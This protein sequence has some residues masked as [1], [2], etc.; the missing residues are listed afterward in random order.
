MT[1]T[2]K[3]AQ[4]IIA[5]E[6]RLFSIGNWVAGPGRYDKTTVRC[7]LE[8]RV[9]MEGTLRRGLWFR[10]YLW[11]SYPDVATFQ[12]E[13]DM[14]NSRS[15]LPIYRL[16]WH[17]LT[18]HRND[19]K[20]PDGLK[21]RLFVAGETHEHLCTYKLDATGENIDMEGS[22]NAAPVMPDP[23]SYQEAFKHVCD[24]LNLVNGGD[25]PSPEFQIP[26]L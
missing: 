13:S 10:I 11:P 2:L 8:A 24:T 7:G 5:T 22:L 15:H 18:T 23:R 1:L 4:R 3:E 26:W 17:P 21:N 20:A 16:D 9:E 12:L 6:K 19:A 25:V 14:V